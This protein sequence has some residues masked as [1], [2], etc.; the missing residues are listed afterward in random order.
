MHEPNSVARSFLTL[1]SGMCTAVSPPVIL[2]VLLSVMT[3]E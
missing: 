2:S 1:P 3:H